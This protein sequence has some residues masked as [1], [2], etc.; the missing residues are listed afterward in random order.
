MTQ[1]QRDDSLDW[2]NE[3]TMDN[4]CYSIA[5]ALVSARGRYVDLMS[6]ADAKHFLKVCL[7]KMVIYT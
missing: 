3:D 6:M 4:I 5:D 1:T 2:E 7:S